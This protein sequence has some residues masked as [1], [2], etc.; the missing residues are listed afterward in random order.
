MNRG[1]EDMVLVKVDHKKLAYISKDIDSYLN[2]QSREMALIDSRL[3]ELNASWNGQDY[4][5]LVREWETLCSAS[6][7]SGKKIEALKKYSGSIK[8][9]ARKYQEVQARAIDRANKLCK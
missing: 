5:Q 7:V 8:E 9:A 4:S 2:A 3:K 1:G 6:S